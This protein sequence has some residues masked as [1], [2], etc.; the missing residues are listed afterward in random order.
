ME[1]NIQ[2]TSVAINFT[3]DNILKNDE[4]VPLLYQ[5]EDK[6][7]SVQE[8]LYDD[9]EF[10]EWIK[11]KDG[12]A[13]LDNYINGKVSWYEYDDN[14]EYHSYSK[15]LYEIWDI[16]DDKNP[17][18]VSHLLYSQMSL[19]YEKCFGHI[20]N[21]KDYDLAI[22]QMYG[23]MK[24]KYKEKITK[25]TITQAIRSSFQQNKTILSSIIDGL[26]NKLKEILNNSQDENI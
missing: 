4:F 20:I 3:I 17:L 23:D 6:S 15:W 25:E 10:L 14:D 8:C 11:Y 16:K 9:G 7:K 1:N 26:V 24:D 12:F 19:L 18:D 13:T 22:Q 5:W 2:N 21:T